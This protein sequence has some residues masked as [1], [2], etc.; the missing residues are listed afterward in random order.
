MADL[1]KIEIVSPES[2]VLS[3]EAVSVTV[4]GQEGYFSVMGEHAPLM[5]TPNQ[6]FHCFFIAVI[7]LDYNSLYGS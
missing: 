4:P 3:A 5:A 7:V 6:N 2:L 1:I